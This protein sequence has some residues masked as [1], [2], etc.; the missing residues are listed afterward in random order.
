MKRIF[1]LSIF[2]V[3]ISIQGG[4]KTYAQSSNY[5]IVNDSLILAIID[6]VNADSVENHIQFLQDMDTR[7]MIAPNRKAVAESIKEKFFRFWF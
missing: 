5:Q 1:I 3:L 4:I 7:F 2:I 6:E